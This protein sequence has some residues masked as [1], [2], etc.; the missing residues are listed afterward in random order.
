MDQS[1]FL[2][3]EPKPEYLQAEISGPFD[4]RHTQNIMAQIIQSC[5]DHGLSKALI[6]MRLIEGTIPI[7][8]RFELAEFVA[9]M[10][11]NVIRMAFIGT[12][13][14]MQPEKFFEKAS[15]NR[16]ALVMVTTDQQEA[17]EWLG[18]DTTAAGNEE[19]KTR[20]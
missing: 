4:V 17:V 7:V 5:R 3:M 20:D 2:K 18:V 15:R 19:P 12:P 14:Q 16:G 6:D 13:E 11:N 10:T 9:L 8:D 1:M